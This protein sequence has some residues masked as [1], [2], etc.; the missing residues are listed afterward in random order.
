MHPLYY[1]ALL[2]LSPFLT[3]FT[4]ITATATP[5]PSKPA[6][7][8]VPGAFHR[9]KVYDHVKSLLKSSGYQH[10]DAVDLPS[11]GPLAAHVDRTPDIAVVRGLLLA[12]LAQGKDVVLVGNSYGATVIGEAVKGLKGR[13]VTA[14]PPPAA[15]G[16]ILGIIMLSGFIPYTTEVSIPNS[17]PDIRALSPPYFLFTPPAPSS[18]LLVTPF[19]LPTTSPPSQTFYNLLPA[20]SASYWTSQLLPSSF[21]ALNATATY[22]PYNGDFRCLY[23]VGLRDNAIP[24]AFAESWLGQSGAVWERVVLDADHVPMLSRGEETV[25]V[26][27]RFVGEAV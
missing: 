27:R 2:L 3:L 16:K 6:V 23:V 22:I 15:G 17:R 5:T 10:V 7:I 12:R 11:V 26:I 8:L 13:S 19:A 14:T 9:A 18:P 1:T 21:A 25:E 24:P 20:S 4:P